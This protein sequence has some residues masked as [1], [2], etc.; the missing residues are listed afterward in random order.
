MTYAAGNKILASDLNTFKDTFNGLWST[1]SGSYGYGQPAVSGSSTGQLIRASDWA[2][3]VDNLRKVLLHQG[4]AFT[5]MTTPTAGTKATSLTSLVPNYVAAEG[6]STRFNS[7]SVGDTTTYRVT[8][9]SGASFNNEQTITITASFGSHDQARYFFNAGGQ[10]D[11]SFSHPTAPLAGLAAG[12]GN[13]RFGAGTQ[14]IGGTNFT[15]TTKLGGT[16]NADSA[17]VTTDNFYNI[18][19]YN[20]YIAYQSISTS[21]LPTMEIYANYN[22]AGTITFTAKS[23]AWT[24][25]QPNSPP[26]IAAGSTFTLTARQ[27]P[28]SYFTNSWGAITFSTSITESSI[29]VVTATLS[30]V[31]NP[32]YC[33]SPYSPAFDGPYNGIAA[34]A[35]LVFYYNGTFTTRSYNGNGTLTDGAWLSSGAPTPLGTGPY[36]IRITKTYDNQAGGGFGGILISPSTGWQTLTFPGYT[37][38][39]V[40]IAVGVDT[41]VGTVVTALYNIEIA[42]DS[43]GNNI[44]ARLNNLEMTVEVS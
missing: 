15:G 39:Y 10:F 7:A 3:L 43:A 8:A 4:T 26:M 16:Y 36:Y 9:T 23:Y 38:G 35:E 20:K 30:G 24:G 17:V 40:R 13:I 32:I 2:P 5:A 11:L 28:T 22:Q 14:T 12:L 6:T 27:P 42:T 18:P 1:G 29:N 34:E 41:S 31:P 25:V 44:V 37:S 21:N 19:A 33:F